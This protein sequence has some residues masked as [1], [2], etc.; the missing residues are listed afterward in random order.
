M[1]FA[2]HCNNNVGPCPGWK[3]DAGQPKRA[4]NLLAHHNVL[5]AQCFNQHV[6]YKMFE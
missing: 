3:F 6:A 1:K 2:I 4:S 5:F